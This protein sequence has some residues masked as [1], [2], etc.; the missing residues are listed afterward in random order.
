MPSGKVE[1]PDG[2]FCFSSHFA[3]AVTRRNKS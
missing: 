1:F 2:I 3:P